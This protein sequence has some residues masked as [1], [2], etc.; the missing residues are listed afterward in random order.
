MTSDGSPDG[1]REVT[2]DTAD[3]VAIVQLNRPD[4]LNAM[5]TAMMRQ[6]IDV[7][8]D[9]NGMSDLRC[10]VVRG[11]GRA[12]CVGAD[13]HERATMS[14]ESVRERRR[15]APQAFGAMRRC[16]LPV[17]AEV[18]GYALGG[19]F[20]LALGSDIVVA[21]ED[22]EMGLVETSR[23]TM[24]AGGGTQLLP[25]LVG[26]AR[27]KELIFTARTFTAREAA[28]WGMISRAVAPDELR[29]ATDDL[30]RTIASV[31][32]ISNIQAKRALNAST[33]MG[34]DNGIAFEAALYERVLGT[35]D[36]A[37]GLAALQEKRSPNFTGH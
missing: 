25:R 9:I 37:E 26:L 2:L 34:L 33:D 30:A 13:R 4:K 23:G 19:G 12:F 36:M 32:P 24:P 18:H 14:A 20:E 15:V 7:F 3:R 17:V 5:N 35:K 11:S 10:V 1:H 22:T 21:A 31:A 29:N 27:A 6:L 16:V 8:D 28:S